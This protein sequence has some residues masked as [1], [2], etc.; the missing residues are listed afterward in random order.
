M[1]VVVFYISILKPVKDRTYEWH[2]SQVLLRK[3]KLLLKIVSK[4]NIIKED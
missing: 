2:R 1:W 3:K 4:Y